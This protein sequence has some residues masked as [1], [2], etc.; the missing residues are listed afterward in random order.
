[1]ISGTAPRSQHRT[2]TTDMRKVTA[3]VAV[4]TYLSEI[5]SHKSFV[6]DVTPIHLMVVYLGQVMAG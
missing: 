5:R 4:N 3:H 6:N 2:A 1:M